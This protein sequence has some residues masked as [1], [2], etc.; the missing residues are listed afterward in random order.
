VEYLG[1]RGD[2]TAGTY[3][4][5]RKQQETESNVVVADLWLDAEV[6]GAIVEFEGIHIFG[7]TQGITLP[8][9][10]DENANDPLLK[11]A[12]IWGYAANVGYGQTGWK[13][14]LEQGYASGDDRV[15][16]NDFTGRPL[17][18]D[19]NVGL[20]LY[21]EVLAHVTR[22]LWTEEGRGLWSRGGVY[23]SRYVFPT[24]HVYPMDN[25]EFLAGFLT[26][27]PDKPDGANIICND[28]DKI[29][30]CPTPTPLQATASTLG[31]ELDLGLKHTW[32]EHLQ[33]RLE[34]GIA[35][36]TDRIPLESVGLNP[37]GKF[38]TMQSG[39]TYRF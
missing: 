23:N 11:T 21:E 33:F 10:F 34:A 25:W 9:S 36:A 5:H 15:T 6:H 29:E 8:G 22:T 39:I 27:W 3:I 1:G 2:L 14:M 17:N 38:F 16:D 19:H 12:N 31:W 13:V 30:S 18:P 26:A 4:V 32:H 37:E 20:L 7:T 28:G 35:H 24:M